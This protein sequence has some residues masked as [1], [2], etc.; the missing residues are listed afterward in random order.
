MAAITRYEIDD[1]KP[2]CG[3]MIHIEVDASFVSSNGGTV[4]V[5]I[6]GANQCFFRVGNDAL[7]KTLAKEI[8]RKSGTVAFDRAIVCSENGATGF[9]LVATPTDKGVNSSLPRRR[10]MVITC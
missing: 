2:N 7:T 8:L 6:A 1:R 5:R 9:D 4:T 3:Q 10:A